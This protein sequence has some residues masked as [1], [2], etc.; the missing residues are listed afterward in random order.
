M[1]CKN[2]KYKLNDKCNWF[3]VFKYKEPRVIP[4]HITTC[5]QSIHKDDKEHPLLKDIIKMFGGNK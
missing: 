2:C 4:K 1:S 5:N 3:K